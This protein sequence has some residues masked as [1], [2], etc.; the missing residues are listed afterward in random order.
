MNLVEIS[1]S[2]VVTCKCNKPQ[3]IDSD[4][5]GEGSCMAIIWSVR[6]ETL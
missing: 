3:S 6:L 1:Q 2:H 4:V 5:I